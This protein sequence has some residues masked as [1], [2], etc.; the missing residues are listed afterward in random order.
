VRKFYIPISPLQEELICADEIRKIA[1]DYGSQIIFY[2]SGKAIDVDNDLTLI[3]NLVESFNGTRSS[4]FV[5][6][7]SGDRLITYTDA[8]Q[9]T[10]ALKMGAMSNELLIGCHGRFSEDG[11]EYVRVGADTRVIFTS[12]DLIRQT[13]IVCPKEQGS[14]IKKN[15]IKILRVPLE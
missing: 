11:G 4:V 9:S 14:Y 8:T 2:D 10:S 5:C 6:I 13:R 15:G 1:A 3:P 12:E 7:K